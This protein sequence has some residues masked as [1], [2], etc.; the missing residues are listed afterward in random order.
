MSEK[1]SKVLSCGHGVGKW[2][3]HFAPG[4]G[5]KHRVW[6]CHCP[7]KKR[8]YFLSGT[9]CKY[10]VLRE[11]T[12]LEWVSREVRDPVTGE[13]RKSWTKKEVRNY[14][15][16]VVPPLWESTPPIMDDSA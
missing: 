2:I 3:C 12:H 6:E 1:I 4:E 5:G 9:T 8:V 16:A 11:E 10:V 14:V 13:T 15:K 7:L